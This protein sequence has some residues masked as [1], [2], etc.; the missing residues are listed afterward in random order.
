V[1]RSR[2]AYFLLLALAGVIGW[3]SGLWAVPI[4]AFVALEAV[5]T[6]AEWT[7]EHAPRVRTTPDDVYVR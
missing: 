7:R 6:A 5:W 3:A 1:E 2:R 4:V